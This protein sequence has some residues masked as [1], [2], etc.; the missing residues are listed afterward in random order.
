MLTSTPSPGQ[1]PFSNPA[2]PGLRAS[3]WRVFL[4]L[5]GVALAY[6]CYT[7]HAWEDYFITYR[8]SKNLALGHGLVFNVG[9]R[10]HSFTSPLGTLLPALASLLTGNTSDVAALWIFRVMS[11]SAFAG[12]GVI[13][14]RLMRG[15]FA[16]WAPAAFLVLLLA[17]DA[18]SVDNATNGMESA[19]VLLFM[20]WNLWALLQRPARRPVHLGLA[21]AGLMWS[22]PD[23]F[24]Y[25][26]ASAGAVLL[27]GRFG[28][29]NTRRR[30]ITDCLL[31][32]VITT[33]VYGPWFA[34]A[35][36]Y[37]GSP[38]PHTIIAKSVWT[39]PV[40]MENVVKWVLR[41]PLDVFKGSS[42]LGTTFTPTYA[43]NTGWPAFT[44]RI[45]AG[46][47]LVAM[48]MWL[49]PRVR[50]EARVTSFV[51]MLAHFYLTNF[52]NF[53]APWYLP[54][55]TMLACF[56]YAAVFGQL[57]DWL[58]RRPPAAAG[59]A[60]PRPHRGVWAAGLV[61]PLW[62]LALMLAAAWELQHR[63]RIVE[64]GNR[65]LVG[66][67]LKAHSAS[68]RDTAVFEC[69]GYI[70]FYSNLKIYDYPGLSS[71]EVVKVLKETKTRADY[72][73]YLPEIVSAYN[74]TWIVLREH[75]RGNFLEAD[76][77]LLKDYY[78][79]AQTFDC[80]PAVEAIKF[81]PG[82]GYLMFDSFFEV[83]RRNEN[84]PD[85][86][87]LRDQP[88]AIRHR[89]TLATLTT[90]E[91]LGVGGKAYLTDGRI[92]AH[93]PSR[94]GAPVPAGATEVLGEFAFFAG[95]YEQHETK[96]AVFTVDAI[97][98][99][100]TRTTLFSR[101]LNPYQVAG[102]RGQQFFTA[103]ITVPNAKSVE[104]VIQPPAGQGNAFGWTYWTNLRFHVPE[105]K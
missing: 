81:L 47:S 27:F 85:L 99:D 57:A 15:M 29:G 74:P 43:M 76:R 19:F 88:N 41:Y 54:I 6:T 31:G 16:H 100:G 91:A 34:W 35:W 39:P 96:G 18:K 11:M 102:D 42:T 86:P 93:M 17:T 4:V 14:W 12:A 59:E 52:A 40:T 37:Y 69:L 66:E 98:A 80:R 7:G 8:A 71:P 75:E 89:I 5:F 10:V 103:K 62:G 64:N 95:A 79:L 63:Q 77:E 44:I 26:A 32:G 60:P 70:G 9:E 1:E 22:R 45:S 51:F 30:L 65:R 24:I 49:V 82:R 101:F 56:T 83:Y 61:L 3:S 13:L 53:P 92:N 78:H 97:S 55:V 25:I 94:L 48:A 72:T 46:L 23:S 84:L 50:W 87:G 104:F 33:A 38:V 28:E 58:A 73:H 36:W 105:N 90:N 67:Y 2:G 68:P 20:A 21:W